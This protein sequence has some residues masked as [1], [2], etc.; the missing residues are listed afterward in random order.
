MYVNIFETLKLKTETHL[1]TELEVLKLFLNPNYKRGKTGSCIFR[2]LIL[3]LTLRDINIKIKIKLYVTKKPGIFI[4]FS[5]I[6]TVI[7]YLV[8]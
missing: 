3:P 5:T 4:L 7:H 8:G 1:S 2:Y 6:I